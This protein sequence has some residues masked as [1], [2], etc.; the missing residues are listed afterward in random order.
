MSN[1]VSET[2]EGALTTPL[3]SVSFK[4]KKTSEF[5]AILSLL[6]LFLIGYAMWEQRED[7]R[8][9]NLTFAS[10]FKDISKSQ[11][12]QNQILREQ[13]CLLSLPEAK[14]E[15]E[16]MSD[17]SLCKRISRERY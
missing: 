12:E 2:T 14:R 15:R 13:V 3:G 4:G 1:D 8:I 16:F 11:R 7:S 10:G 17:N 6:V 9:M 5:I